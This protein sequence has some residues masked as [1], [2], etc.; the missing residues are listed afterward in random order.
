MSLYK[1]VLPFHIITS[2][3]FCVWYLFFDGYLGF[4]YG[5]IFYFVPI[6]IV[7]LGSIFLVALHNKTGRFWRIFFGILMLVFDFSI[8]SLFYSAP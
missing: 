6:A 2:F 1:I 3:S 4:G 8:I 7:T 5:D